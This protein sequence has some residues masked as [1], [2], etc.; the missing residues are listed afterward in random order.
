MQPISFLLMF[1]KDGT[2][3]LKELK[4]QWKNHEWPKF[5][6]NG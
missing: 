3:T 4:G 1:G 2:R 6:D 5:G